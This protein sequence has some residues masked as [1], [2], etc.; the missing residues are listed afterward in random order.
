MYAFISLATLV[1]VL[2]G[3]CLDVCCSGYKQPSKSAADNGSEERRAF[4]GLRRFHRSPARSRFR[5]SS[6]AIALK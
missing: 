6:G 3:F 1:G 2:L 5:R 4:R